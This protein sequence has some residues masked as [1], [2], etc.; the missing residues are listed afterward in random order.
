M[1]SF[2]RALAAAVVISGLAVSCTGTGTGALAG[3]VSR[4]DFSARE[5]EQLINAHRARHG[6]K[7]VRLD[8][9][10]SRAAASHA[11]DMANHNTFAH[12]VSAGS[13]GTRVAAYGSHPRLVA[14]NISAGRR[15]VS[16]VIAAWRRSP[17][18]NR[19]L[20]LRDASRM[21]IAAVHAPESRYK[22]YWTLIL[23]GN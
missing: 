8:S 12:R 14:E 21:G 9:T 10:L 18:H 4:L 7:P 15:N 11:R 19:N 20:L 16:D 5:A 13:L 3:S 23:A 1:R 6:L 22:S 17:G 2:L